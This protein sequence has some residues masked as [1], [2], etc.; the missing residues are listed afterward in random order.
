MQNLQFLQSAEGDFLQMIL[1]S[2]DSI[3]LAEEDQ[4]T[5]KDQIM[6][7]IAQEEELMAQDG[8]NISSQNDDFLLYSFW[9]VYFW[10]DGYFGDWKDGQMLACER[11]REDVHDMDGAQL[12]LLY[13]EMLFLMSYKLKYR[14]PFTSLCNGTGYSDVI[15]GSINQ[16]YM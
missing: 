8:C 7:K 13:G 6:Q 4:K 2:E 16:Q 1:V 3:F 15:S 12:T 10:Y 11:S 14:L 5:L 9:T